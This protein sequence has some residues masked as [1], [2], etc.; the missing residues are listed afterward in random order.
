MKKK[1][2]L[3]LLIL[4]VLF[5]S[6]FGGSTAVSAASSF[7]RLQAV[8][9]GEIVSK[10]NNLYYRYGQRNYARNKYLRIKG[11]NYYFDSSGKAWYG[12]HTINGRKYYF[13]TR[14]EG[15]MYRSRLF[16]YNKNYYYADQ[17]GILVTSGWYTLPSGKKYYFDSAGRAYTGKRTINKTTYYFDSNGLLNHSG[18]YYDLASDCA[19]LINADT[20]KV[21]YSKNENLRHA[22]A[23][24]TK[25]MTCILALENSKMNETVKFSARAT[26]LEPTK[27]Y[28]RTGET[29][30]MR[31]LLYSLMVPSHNDTAAAIAEH[32]SGSQSKFVSLMNKKA[33]QLGC[34]DTHFATPNGL[35]AGYT[36]YTT[37]SDL[38]KIA[39]YAIKKPAF[40]KIIST[41]SYSFK[42]L[43]TNRRFTVSTTNALLGNMPGVIGMKTGYT[44][45]AGHCFVGLCQSQKGNTYISVVLGGPNSNARWRDSRILL[46]YAYKH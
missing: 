13:G 24:T 33:V 41:K 36:H 31:D 5:V 38:A 17:K 28:A 34:T 14:S 25:I 9:S 27:L 45:K 10:N 18:L 23:S 15:Y 1:Q 30:Y 16:R 7:P 42:S 40:R 39:R 26:A 19:L 2:N 21:L 8:S 6:L 46:N 11:K 4:A 32:I 44:N 22:N 37:A 20:G 3:L 43:N 29:F 12:M 35:D